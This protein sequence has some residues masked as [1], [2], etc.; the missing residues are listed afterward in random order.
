LAIIESGKQMLK[1]R[2]RSDMPGFE[3][4]PVYQQ[5]QQN[6]TMRQQAEARNRKAIHNGQ[7]LYD[8]D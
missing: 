5:R 4:C 3:A 6:Y 1:G 2:Q 7:R 8:F